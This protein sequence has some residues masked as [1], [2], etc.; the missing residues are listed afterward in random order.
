MASD[1]FSF[2][3]SK[4]NVS[5]K[6][7]PKKKK[8]DLLRINFFFCCTQLCTVRHNGTICSKHQKSQNAKNQCELRLLSYT[9]DY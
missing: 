8:F 1:V 3:N 5:N 4:E 9:N 2:W 6:V 7:I